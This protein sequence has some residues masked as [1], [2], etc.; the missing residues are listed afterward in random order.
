MQQRVYVEYMWTTCG[1][2]AGRGAPCVYV[3]IQP[4]L[5]V[6]CIVRV[7]CAFL[8]LCSPVYALVQEDLYVITLPTLRTLDWILAWLRSDCAIAHRDWLPRGRQAVSAWLSEKTDFRYKTSWLQFGALCC[9][10]DCSLHVG[11]AA[12]ILCGYLSGLDTTPFPL[13]PYPRFTAAKSGLPPLVLC[14]ALAS[15]YIR[16]HPFPSIT[17][18]STHP[19]THPPR[20]R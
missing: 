5:A 6:L 7:D 10:C 19:S 3:W 4:L 14:T 13:V 16:L 18:S 9:M 11:G 12:F 17:S 20:G 8:D 2:P 15:V 1:N